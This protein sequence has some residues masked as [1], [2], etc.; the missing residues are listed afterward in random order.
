MTGGSKLRLAVV[1]LGKMGMLHWRTW[2]AI[3]DVELV[4]G[5]DTD[6]RKA[7]RITG[8]LR[9]CHHRPEDLLGHIDAAV[10]ATPPEQHLPC[11]LPLLNAGIHCLIEKPLALNLADSTKLI[12]AAAMHQ[13][14]LAVGHSERFNPAIQRA[15]EIPLSGLRSIE[16]FRMST[17]GVAMQEDV[18]HDLMVH[19]LDWLL[20]ALDRP[21]EGIRIMQADR[22]GGTLSRVSCEL[23]FSDGPVIRVTASRI[24]KMRRRELILHGTGGEKTHIDLNCTPF[25]AGNDPLTLQAHAFLH[26]LRG[27]ASSIATGMEILPAM[28]LGERIREACPATEDSY[29][30]AEETR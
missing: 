8:G 19:D 4:A 6:R 17:P 7:S 5:V 2:Q 1:G 23:L 11:A 21:A 10:I 13:A 24:E 28:A 22:V 30:Y 29:S 9:G 3:P 15:R 16:V 14:R 20:N 12:T 25:K 26:L 18:V 27:N